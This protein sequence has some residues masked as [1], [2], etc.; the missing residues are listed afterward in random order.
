MLENFVL[1][2]DI[3]FDDNMNEMKDKIFGKSMF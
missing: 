2:L 3:S 1:A